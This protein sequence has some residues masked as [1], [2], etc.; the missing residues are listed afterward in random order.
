MSS[1]DYAWSKKL[2]KMMTASEA[3][4]SWILG[5]LT[6]KTE[7]ECID[8][9]CNAQITCVNM[10]KQ[11]YQMKMREHFKVYGQHSELCK[12][13][14]KNKEVNRKYKAG[15]VGNAPEI[16][17]EITFNMIRLISHEVV[18]THTTD[19]DDVEGAEVVKKIVNQTK[20]RQKKNGTRKSHLYL[21]STLVT[22][23]LFGLKHGTLNELKVNVS[24][25]GNDKIYN[26][27][28]S[29]LFKDITKT[30]IIP[31]YNQRMKI[32]FGNVK[33][34]KNQN[35]DYW[36]YFKRTFKNNDRK[37]YC[38]INQKIIDNTLSKNASKKL[39]DKFLYKEDVY[40]F[41]FGKIKQTSDII[42]INIESLDHLACTFKKIDNV[43]DL[44]EYD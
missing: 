32:F 29:T 16:E 19:T 44:E 23:Y 12:E 14:K 35:G 41:L 25:P 30:I 10:D 38:V 34:S 7:F 43:D 15:E 3:H 6:D 28:F 8:E 18:E 9:K 39:L 31:E 20:E 36:I 24:F 11:Q 17:E 37:V 5:Y 42:F 33:I 2:N 27:S 40:C 26:F 4:E 22:K 13:V 1:V 21:L